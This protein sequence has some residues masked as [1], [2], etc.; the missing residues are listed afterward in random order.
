[1]NHI[2]ICKKMDMDSVDM[3]INNNVTEYLDVETICKELLNKKGD[4]QVYDYYLYIENSYD[5]SMLNKIYENVK[6]KIEEIKTNKEILEEKYLKLKKDS[7]EKYCHN[8]FGSVTVCNLSN[9]EVVLVS[10]KL[11]RSINYSYTI[12]SHELFSLLIDLRTELTYQRCLLYSL[13]N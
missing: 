7:K 1:M 13:E 3:D 11:E 4:R 2:N 5:I 8:I 6:K 12:T 9:K 10:L